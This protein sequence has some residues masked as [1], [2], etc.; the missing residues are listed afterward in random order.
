MRTYWAQPVADVA[1][2]LDA[3]TEGLTSEEAAHR[4]AQFGPNRIQA[5]RS[6]SRL[7]VAWR[8]V[9]SPL[10]LLLVFAASA[11]LFTSEWID[12]AIVG[13]ILFASVVI[14]YRR[15]YRA[16]TTIAALLERIQLT[17]EVVRDGQRR[18]VP[19]RDVVPGDLVTLAAGSIVPADGVLLEA[20]DLH[21]DEAALTGESFPVFKR[22]GPV[23]ATAALRDRFGC[24]HSGTNVRS[25][26]G[27]VLVVATGARTS[28]G[29]VAGRLAS[30]TPETEFEHGL[31]RFGL[32]LLVAMLVMILVV[33][34]V[35]VVLG[36]PAIE[37]LLFSIALAVGLSPELLP[38]I[39]AVNL[40][41]AAQV[42]AH[43]G[44]LVRHLDALENLGSMTVLCTDKT[45]TL[46]QGVVRVDGAYD[47]HG[48]ESPAVLEL[49][50]VN[51]ALQTG[52]PNPIDAALLAAHPFE[53][54]AVEK[55]AE[56]PYDF[57]RKRLSV[58]VR[59]ADGIS[60]ITKG[61]FA[62]VLA[63][64]NLDAAMRAELDARHEAWSAN[65]VRVLAVATKKLASAER[66]D[67]DAERDLEL[68][69][70]IAL[71]DRVKPDAAAAI[72]ALAAHRVQVKMITGDSRFVARHV[73]SEVGLSC[74]N[75]VT[76]TDLQ[77]L[78]EAALV[79]VVA[80][81]EVF[82]EVDPTQKERILRAL[83]RGGAVV[84]FF[85]D[86][87][88]DAPAMHV[89]D[90]AISVESAVDVAR[91]TA[92]LVL[93]RKSLD[94]IRCGIEEGRRTFANTLKYVLTTTS[95]NLGN[96]VSMAVASL[97]L[98]FLPLTA[99]QVLL[100]N[101]LSDIP[102]VGIASDS[103]D[104]ELVAAPRRWDTRFIGRFMFEFGLLSSLFDA[105]TFAILILG[106]RADAIEFRTGWFVESLF[107]ELVI[108]LVVRTRRRAWR[109]RPGTTLLWTSVVVAAIAFALPVSPIAGVLGFGQP[110]VTMLLAIV[111][112]TIAYV[113]A[114]EV[115]KSWFYRG[116]RA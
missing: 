88:N 39:V 74:T 22:V 111:V 31:Q 53:P 2:S 99:G 6:T 96:M 21:V 92:D 40:A 103:V 66:Y 32:L 61:A 19:S 68:V 90:V 48:V 115:L 104:P 16:E 12:A 9:R 82:A 89:A 93:T 52:L 58:I 11:S 83:R 15:E 113:L 50:V 62:S 23:A 78:T 80:N 79:H 29:A 55:I 108:A 1:H 63:S 51:A 75:I 44:V 101:F 60:I 81:A 36:R 20:T 69:G 85:G 25:G 86:G 46:T 38:A 116:R 3:G 95:A 43:D 56:I 91:A 84:G 100:N 57:T 98:P 10:V 14:G 34:A 41:R 112:I 33:F 72:E 105:V 76:G 67:H 54:G 18:T 106:F 7:H 28:F 102:A 49:A 47:A 17:A 73:A 30:R 70:F 114:S 71:T 64:C 110:P 27:L 107:T 5:G 45:G 42:L 26:T 109:S 24:V 35:N 8:Q 13:A 94:V 37:T 65:G 87:V 97:V 59:R 77:T 4:L